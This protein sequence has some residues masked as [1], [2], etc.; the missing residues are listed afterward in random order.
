MN[1]TDE[2]KARIEALRQQTVGIL[3]D[4]A[5][6]TRV[7]DL[8]GLPTD[9]EKYRQKLAAN[10]YNVL[11]IGEAKRGKSSFV[12]A[13]IGRE[14]LPTDVD[15]TTSQVFRICNSQK[16]AYRLCF[17]DGPPRQ[18]SKEELAEYGSQA[19]AD[20]RGASLVDLDQLLWIEVDVPIRYLPEGVAL[21]DTPGL[22]AIYAKHAMITHAL[23][24]EADAVI[25]VL[26]SRQPLGELDLEF[27]KEICKV[28]KQIFFIQTKIDLYDER[29]WEQQ[30]RRHM[31]ILRQHFG[32]LPD[33]RVWPISNRNLLKFEETKNPAYQRDSRQQELVD[34]LE[35]FLFRVSG[36]SRYIDALNVA[37]HYQSASR[38]VLAERLSTVENSS[39]QELGMLKDSA[40][41][42]GQQLESEWG[43]SGEK[44][45]DLR[46][47][48]RQIVAS[49]KQNIVE[50]LESGG[51]LETAQRQKIDAA[52]SLKEIDD[53]GRTMY[54]HVAA[55]AL[56]A[57]RTTYKETREQCAQLLGS[58]GETADEIM[59][60]PNDP[61]IGPRPGSTV[62]E[63][64]SL[65][66]LLSEARNDFLGGVNLG[67]A[68]A[69]VAIIF[70]HV[71]VPA[72][73][74]GIAVAGVLAAAQGWKDVGESQM[75]EARGN[76]QDSLFKAMQ[77]MRKQFLQPNLRYGGAS[78]VNHDFDAIFEEMDKQIEEI[79]EIKVEK[80]RQ[81]SALLEE[82][83]KMSRQE[84]MAQAEKFRQQQAAWDALG[85]SIRAAAEELK[86]VGQT[87]REE[88]SASA[89]N[90]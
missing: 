70:F 55:E 81:E 76:L 7:F 40:T 20:R 24:P 32:D 8:P 9:L 2:V 88:A 18:I 19:V 44:R 71:A 41:K 77:E 6:K 53:L 78:L 42:Q 58:I 79:V 75:K 43:R 15:A 83:A 56:S 35:K 89:T 51:T 65:S 37:G 49:G 68:A 67:L 90:M 63:K 1:D 62:P 21:L 74:V 45:R 86:E 5:E 69:P 31:E 28:T 39:T 59:L 27:L 33:T 46:G 25:Y 52:K 36:G 23:V 34:A 13:L 64:G 4:L 82:Q 60:V 47:R 14:L 22:G 11:V 26:D 10:T 57:W 85:D 50:L 30:Q 38:N 48:A 16:E 73:L 29:E 3:E 72:V 61:N 80:A 17:K 54:D 87:L 12:N 66:N 84:R